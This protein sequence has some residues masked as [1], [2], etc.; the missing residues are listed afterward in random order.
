MSTLNPT[1]KVSRRH[2]LREDTVVTAYARALGYFENNRSV[3]FGAAAVILLI[4]TLIVG[5]SWN[6]FSILNQVTFRQRW[7]EMHPS[8]V[9]SK[10]QIVMEVRTQ[11]TWPTIT[12]VMPFS[13]S[14]I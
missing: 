4:A 8:L 10:L 7:M 3:V 11:A 5:L 9:W 14:V 12:L 1:R 2:E 6:P 13:A